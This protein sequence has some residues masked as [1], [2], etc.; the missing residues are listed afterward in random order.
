MIR[1]LAHINILSNDLA[2]TEQ[3]YCGLLGLKKGF[4]FLK[5]GELFGF[6]LETGETTFIEVFL[7]SSFDCN[8]PHIHHLCLEVE[9]LDA[10]I[11]TIRS[12]GGEITDK[13][14]GGDRSWQAWMRDPAGVNIELMQYTPESSQFTGNPCIVDW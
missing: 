3:F 6:Y 1:R 7:Q 11:A 12:K 4:E 2:A 9:D 8:R 10:T 14:Q 13:K 5:D